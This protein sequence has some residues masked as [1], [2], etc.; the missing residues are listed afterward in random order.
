MSIRKVGLQQ[1]NDVLDRV[2]EIRKEWHHSLSLG[3]AG[4]L[5]ERY[6]NGV[7]VIHLHV[8]W[9]GSDWRFVYEWAGGIVSLS[10][11][12]EIVRSMA[13]RDE[14]VPLEFEFRQSDE[15]VLVSVV[16]LAE[17]VKGFRS[18]ITPSMIGLQT[19]DDCLSVRGKPGNHGEPLVHVFSDVPEDWELS[20]PRLFLGASA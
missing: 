3:R 1:L 15:T 13:R 17:N 19:L 10:D 14:A 12:G 5:S 6:R 20:T 9:H 7:L 8:R 11:A 18:R 16:E 2:A 4:A